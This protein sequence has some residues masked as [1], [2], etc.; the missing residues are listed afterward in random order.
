VGPLQ[1]L[2]EL[3]PRLVEESVLLAADASSIP[4]R[5][6]YRRERNAIYEI[7]DGEKREGEFLA[8][9]ARWFARLGI[10]VPLLKLLGEFEGVLARV[11][12]CLVLLASRRADEGADLHESRGRVPVL[13]VKLTPASLVDLDRVA[14]LVRSEL[15]HVA[16]MLDP[17]FGYERDPPT[18]GVDPTYEKLVKDRYRV[19]WNAS[20][21]GRLAARDLLPEGASERG[22]R[23]FLAAFPMLGPEAERHFERFFSGPRPSHG[24]LLRF[25]G[26]VEGRASGRCP[27][28]RFPTSRLRGEDEPLEARVDESIR[29]DFP[30][31]PGWS[32]SAGICVQCADLYEARASS[33]ATMARRP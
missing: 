11:S 24:E 6:R 19:L 27:L 28:C 7:P 26:D 12:R 22:R 16:D 29:R 3:D 10:G 33:G 2:V 21:D 8:L 1:N 25:A 14:P 13:A 5:R 15:L 18:P 17:A 32:A 9:D 31:W 30:D 4:L 20:V 23:E